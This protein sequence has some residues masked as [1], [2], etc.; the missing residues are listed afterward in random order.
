[1]GTSFSTLFVLISNASSTA[2][3]PNQHATL[4]ERIA[5]RTRLSSTIALLSSPN[6]R[7]VGRPL[8]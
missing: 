7:T 3:G 4:G 5:A 6:T 1:M 2:N 8:S